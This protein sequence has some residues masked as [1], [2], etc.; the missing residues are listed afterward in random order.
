[1]VFDATG[2]RF[3]GVTFISCSGRTYHRVMSMFIR[4]I[5]RPPEGHLIMF[6]WTSGPLGGPP[7]HPPESLNSTTDIKLHTVNVKTSQGRYVFVFLGCQS[8]PSHLKCQT[9]AMK[10]WCDCPRFSYRSDINFSRLPKLE[11]WGW[12]G[13]EGGGKSTLWVKI[14]LT[15]G[16]GNEGTSSCWRNN[17]V[18]SVCLKD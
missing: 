6:F 16:A 8:Q 12:E 13:G 5:E 1:M 4:Y 10:Q 15:L 2:W 14:H 11:R 3:T 17:G 9:S 18:L 7:P